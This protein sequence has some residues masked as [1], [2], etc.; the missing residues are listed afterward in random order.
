MK[1]G[2]KITD[3]LFVGAGARIVCAHFEEKNHEK[4][5]QNEYERIWSASPP[6]L[7]Q[8]KTNKMASS[9]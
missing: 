9:I 4:V 8:Q 6:P 7:T 5:L 3:A 2:Y 1:K